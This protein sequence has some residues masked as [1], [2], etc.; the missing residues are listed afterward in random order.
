VADGGAAAQHG[1]GP[2]SMQCYGMAGWSDPCTARAT[3]RNGP[4]NENW[5]AVNPTDPRNVVVMGKDYN[6]KASDCVWMGVEVSKDGGK[7]WTE[8]YLGGDLSQRA[9]TDASYGY[10]CNT[11]PM[12][13][14]DAQG[15]LYASFEVYSRLPNHLP[16]GAND[17]VQGGQNTM[18][19]AVSHDGGLT[20][21]PFVAVWQ[22]DGFVVLQDRTML[23]SNPKTGSIH[24]CWT[25][26][27]GTGAIGEVLVA[28]SRDGGASWDPPV[29]VSRAND[30]RLDIPCAVAAA[31]DGT[32]YAGWYSLPY[33][34]PS[35]VP[36]L[37]EQGTHLEIAVSTDDGRTYS[38]PRTVQD[39]GIG[40]VSYAPHTQFY[41]AVDLQMAV[42]PAGDLYLVWNDNATGHLEVMLSRSADGGATFGPAVAVAGPG[43]GTHARFHGAVVVDAWNRVHVTYFDRQ[44][45]PGDRLLDLTWASS[46]DGAN[47]THRRVTATSFDGDLGY[48][49]SGVPFIGDYNGLA[50][51][52]KDLYASFPDTRAGRSDLAV[53]HLVRP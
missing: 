11:D 7:T 44:Y 6:P 39:A 13:T 19:V 25:Q 47:F 52:G 8:S 38:A 37:G 51:A 15:T 35:V 22:G 21:G 20:F 10:T 41:V 24:F 26:R 32:V 36:R 48:H 9:P 34:S 17:P 29:I 46:D 40:F 2:W 30:D 14:F 33:Q 5:I 1:E 45:D 4:S 50:V 27:V 42:A 16:G 49:Q 23:V 12:S 43:A 28:T 31:P 53:A 18:F 3:T